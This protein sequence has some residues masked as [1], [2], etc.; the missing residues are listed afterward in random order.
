MHRYKSEQKKIKV[1]S[2]EIGGRP[3]LVPTVMIGS[4][5]Y[6]K[7]KLVDN[8]KTGE[9]DRKNTE[10][11]LHRLEQVSEKTGIPS[12]LDIIAETPVAMENYVRLLGE[13]T[14]MPLMVDGS[15]SQDV[16]MAGLRIANDLGLIDRVILNSIGPEDGN[17]T[18]SEYLETGLKTAMLLAFSSEA[19]PSASKRVELAVS[20]ID[21]ASNAGIDNLMVDT[22]VVDLLTLGLACKAVSSIKDETGVPAGCGAHN[23]VNMWTGLVPKFGKDAKRPAQVGSSLMP[24]A[25]GADFI[26]YGPIRHAPVV[27]PSVAMVDVALSGAL[28]EE[29]IRPDRSHPRFRIG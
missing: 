7:D 20:L 23:A 22:G 4:I 1:G 17:E 8:P 14:E 29:G 19:M 5:F 27:F 24:V 16:N 25:L 26:L 15:G 18:I 13:M 2:V 12:I 11:L 6:T 21:R 28:L 10:V 9:I 3:G